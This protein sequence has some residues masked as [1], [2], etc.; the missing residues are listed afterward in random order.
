MDNKN[1]L[2]PVF[3]V[4]KQNSLLYLQSIIIILWK[5]FQGNITLILW[6]LG[7]KYM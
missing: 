2:F 6:T 7:S 5:Y 3:I 1:Q 4:Y